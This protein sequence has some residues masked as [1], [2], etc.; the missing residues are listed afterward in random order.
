M[1][2]DPLQLTRRELLATGTALGAATVLPGRRLV[3]PNI[4]FLCSDQQHWEA[5]GHVDPFF[6]TPNLDRLAAAGTRFP[7]AF[8]T[9]PQCSP[10]RS[11]M[12]SGRYP[13]RTG[14]QNNYGLPGGKKFVG[15]TIGHYLQATG[16]RTAWFGKWHLGQEEHLLSEWNLWSFTEDDRRTAKQAK[17]YLREQSDSTQP[18]ALFV[19]LLEPHGI[20]KFKA[21]DEEAPDFEVPFDESFEKEDLSAKP[22]CQAHFEKYHCTK[23]SG[24]PL[25]VWRKF[26]ARYRRLVEELDE[27]VGIVLGALEDAGLAENTIVVFTSDHGEMDTNH[28]LIFKG[29]FLYEHLVRIPA[30]VRLPESL[31]GV[32]GR[33]VSDHHL[34]NVDFVPTLL[35]FAGADPIETDGVSLRPALLGESHEPRTTVIAQF[36]GKKTWIC[37]AR[38]IR[39]STRKYVRYTNGWEELYDLER[40]PGELVDLSKSEEYAADKQLLATELEAWMTANDDPFPTYE[41]REMP[42]PQRA[43]IRERLNERKQK[44]GRQDR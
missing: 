10:S 31:G 16:Y 27:N 41:P 13:H 23:V 37:P 29:P 19:S 7:N 3:R 21:A 28:R 26:R 20:L 9:T 44:K 4:L 1:G 14:I 30:I 15:R 11:S 32:P 40:D 17:D 25:E 38:M 18:F 43:L 35:D 42:I 5:L 22:P 12:V 2:Y 24:K 36:H 39:T 34:V 6:V 33:V 8:C